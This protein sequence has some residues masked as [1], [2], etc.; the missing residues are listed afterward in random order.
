MSFEESRVEW[1]SLSR[2][3]VT[4]LFGEVY[5]KRYPVEAGRDQTAV[6][7]QKSLFR[8]DDSVHA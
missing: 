7:L 3:G 8:Q 4:A 6:A 2:T 1:Q 5:V